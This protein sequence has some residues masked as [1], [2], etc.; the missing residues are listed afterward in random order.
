LEY[1]LIIEKR[2]YEFLLIREALE[3]FENSEEEKKLGISLPVN[4]T[5]NC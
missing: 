2:V 4:C 3:E 1:G 5:G